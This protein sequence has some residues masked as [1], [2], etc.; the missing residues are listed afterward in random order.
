M[1]IPIYLASRSPR[2]VA[3]LA[4]M[5]LQCEVMPMDIDESVQL[6]ELPTT[7]V[8]RLAK[9][10]AEALIQPQLSKDL[11]V[12]PSDIKNLTDLP[13]EIKNLTVF[14]GHISDRPCIII[15]ADTTVATATDF[16]GKPDNDAHAKSMLKQL[17]DSMHW[18][19]TA[20][21]VSFCHAQSFETPR[22]FQTKVALSST[23]VRMMALSDAQIDQYIA[24]GEHRDKAGSYGIQGA[25]G[26]WITHIEGSYTGVMGLPVYE[27]AAL[28]R[29]FG[30]YQL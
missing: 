6:N 28:L 21:A 18:V 26:A 20:V 27:T 14:D 23:A 15:A 19:H 8:Q 11:M 9:E 4:Q 1:T 10:K 25:A 16:L 13:C 30:V 12:L 5:G 7:Y 24:T 29:S 22:S 3:L 2:R 17:S